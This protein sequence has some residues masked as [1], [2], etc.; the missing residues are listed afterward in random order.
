M[1]AIP[2]RLTFELTDIILSKNHEEPCSPHAWVRS[3]TD[4]SAAMDNFQLS[5]E[6]KHQLI[7]DSPE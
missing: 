3:I 4:N 6:C 2:Y 7:S 1:T 5:F